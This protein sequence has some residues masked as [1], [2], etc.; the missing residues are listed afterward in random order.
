MLKILLKPLENYDQEKQEFIPAGDPVELELEHSLLS[1]YKFEAKWG[2]AFLKRDLTP[3]ERMDY[4]GR[5]MPLDSKG[6]SSIEI[7]MRLS[8]EDAKRIAEYI[9]SKQS[10]TVIV[11]LVDDKKDSSTQVLTAEVIYYY[12]FE[13]NIPLEFENR[14][15]NHLMMLIEVISFQRQKQNAKDNKYSKLPKEA[16]EARRNLNKQRLAQLGKGG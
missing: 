9:S 4:V 16:V 14:H 6:L 13:L 11:K 8:P 12:M 3:E 1:V 2:H 7:M 10:A 5:C 15:L